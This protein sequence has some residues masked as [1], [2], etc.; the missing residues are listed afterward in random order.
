MRY[1][2]FHPPVLSQLNENDKWGQPHADL[3]F[4]ALL[5]LSS[6][7]NSLKVCPNIQGC[8]SFSFF[9]YFSVQL[10]SGLDKNIL[11]AVRLVNFQTRGKRRRCLIQA[12]GVREGSVL[13]RLFQEPQRGG[14][15]AHLIS[16]SQDG[17]AP[18]FG[19]FHSGRG[20]RS[21]VWTPRC[22]Q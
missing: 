6:L 10:T 5:L 21:L 3:F 18:S 14:K 1:F 2:G 22:Y 20:Q 8:F 13:S 17:R 7:G 12:E 19:L 11:V 4:L 16:C 15:A 9:L